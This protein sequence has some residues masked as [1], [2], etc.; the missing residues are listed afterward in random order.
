VA[1]EGQLE[2]RQKNNPFNE[3]LRQFLGNRMYQII[4]GVVVALIIMLI[5]IG[6]FVRAGSNATKAG[7]NEVEKKPNSLKNSKLVTVFEQLSPMDAAQIREALSYENI[8]FE[9]KKEGRIINISVPK[10][11]A[12]EARV[13]MAQHGLP[14]G[15]IVGF[16]I[17]DKSQSMGAT[18]YDKR[19]QYIRAISGELSR[20]ISKM[21]GINTARV[22]IVIP[23]QK[24]F[25]EAVPG[26]ASV[27]LSFKP[28]ATI[29][30]KQIR[31]IMHLIASSVEHL[32]P[33][34]VV[35]LDNSG[36]ML[37]DR[38]KIVLQDTKENSLY[39]MLSEKSDET[40]S[41][42]E[43]LMRFKNQLKK[44]IE[45]EYNQKIKEVLTTLYPIGSFLIF[46]NVSLKESENNNSPYTFDKLDVAILIDS[47]NKKLI[48]DEQKKDTTTRLVSSAIGYVPSRDS[49]VIER[50]PL[51]SIVSDGKEKATDKANSKDKFFNKSANNQYSFIF[52][53]IYSFV[54]VTI[55]FVVLIL[56]FYNN[57]KKSQKGTAPSQPEQ[58]EVSISDSDFAKE[59]FRTYAQNN[60]EKI[61][62][63]IKEWMQ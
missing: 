3:I 2:G 57:D 12:D 38:V 55:I 41:P 15:G 58:E 1:D 6:L 17:F 31:G 63:K 36:N 51:T 20:I 10:K 49:L 25:G 22:Q 42:L 9:S 35:V 8:P 34:D 32:K 48:F 40:K 16:E 43:L 29:N 47:N 4:A 11:L 37:S 46:T 61:L 60:K 30:D 44:N 27:V 28:K 39:D 45:S 24:A 14:E 33:E 54:L 26:N 18:D 59:K 19:I 13:M 53:F 56:R 50:S 21:K 5:V 62:D 7:T 52:K 23:E